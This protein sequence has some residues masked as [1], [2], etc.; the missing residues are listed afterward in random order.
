ML[1]D[2]IYMNRNRVMYIAIVRT[3]LNNSHIIMECYRYHHSIGY[4]IVQDIE[5]GVITFGETE[6]NKCSFLNVEEMSV[7]QKIMKAECIILQGFGIATSCGKYW[8]PNIHVALNLLIH[9]WV[10][11]LT[12]L[13]EDERHCGLANNDALLHNIVSFV[14]SCFEAFRWDVIYQHCLPLLT[15]FVHFTIKCLVGSSMFDFQE[16]TDLC[17]TIL[18]MAEVFLREIYAWAAAGDCTTVHFLGDNYSPSCDRCPGPGA[19]FVGPSTDKNIYH[20]YKLDQSWLILYHYVCK[21]YKSDLN[22]G[23]RKTH[24]P[25]ERLVQT[26]CWIQRR[27]QATSSSRNLILPK[28]LESLSDQGW[29]KTCENRKRTKIDF[30]SIVARPVTKFFR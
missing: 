7:K 11:L 29:C 21:K 19:Y 22:T 5:A 8:S 26:L 30:A 6:D 17:K 1:I 18:R 15:K 13:L 20:N 27:L 12:I 28:N 16:I 14:Q 23:V 2:Q 10:K 9:M 4:G 3:P 25:D 24:T